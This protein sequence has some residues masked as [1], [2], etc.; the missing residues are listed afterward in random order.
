[1]NTSLARSCAALASALLMAAHAPAQGLVVS[2]ITDGFVPIPP[3]DGITGPAG[4]AIDPPGNLYMADPYNCVVEK[5]SPTGINVMTV[6]GIGVRGS[7]DGPA[8]LAQFNTPTGLA[9]DAAGNLYVADQMNST[10]RRV[11]PAGVVSTVAGVPNTYGHLDGPAATAQFCQP[12]ALAFDAAGNLYVADGANGNI[13]LPDAPGHAIRKIT[14]TGSVTTVS[15]LHEIDAV[16]PEPFNLAGIAIDALGDIFVSVGP[17]D[18]YLSFVDFYPP[19]GDAVFELSAAGVVSLYAGQPDVRGSADGAAL[20]AQF[21]NPG[22]LALD[23]AGYLFVADTGNATLREISPAGLVTTI[24]GS[25]GKTGLVDGAR[26]QAL[27]TSPQA[28]AL[29][30][31]G[32]V[33]F[34]DGRALRRGIPAANT[35]SPVRFANLSARGT[36]TPTSTLIG[37]FVI[38]GGVSQTVLARGV[39]PSLSPF[40]VSNPLQSAQLDIYNQAGALVASSAAGINATNASSAAA[41]VGAFPL[42]AAAGDAPLVL[43]LNPGPYTAV[44]SS[45]SGASGTALVEIY[46]LP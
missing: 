2:T 24:A 13:N 38:E 44:V 43:T 7:L 19:N 29:D 16:E 32:N 26:S 27:L 10:I 17:M 25:P 6:G 37:G 41:L 22:G 14:P 23:A 35:Q 33:F 21:I 20:Q 5:F 40:G 3:S 39:G 4:V 12:T 34:T 28:V 9:L 42:G 1:M 11:T 15:Y 8:N 30:A 18:G 45:P 31:S 46:E 36:V